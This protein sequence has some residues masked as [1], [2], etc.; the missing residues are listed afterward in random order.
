MSEQHEEAL[1]PKSRIFETVFIASEIVVIL[2]YAF[3][4]TYNL[5]GM[6]GK[7]VSAA[8]Q[9]ETAEKMQGYY[10]MWQDVHVMIYIGFG[11]LMVFLKT[12]SWSAVGFNFLLSAWA[13]QWGILTE[14]FWHQVFHNHFE[15]I[16]L[17][18]TYLVLGDFCAAACM[19][20]FGA[21]LGKADLYQLWLLITI[22]CIFYSLN[23]GIGLFV[24]KAADAGG[25]MFIHTFGAYFGLAATYFFQ[26]TKA[27]KEHDQKCGGGY[28]S[29]YV[30]ML[31]TIFLYLYWPSFN[32]AL[33]P[34]ISKQRAVFTT[35]LSISASCIA[36]CGISRLIHM[37]LD[38][39]IVLNAT[40]AGGVMVGASCDMI[41]NPG[42]AIII[43][44]V[45]GTISALGFAYLSAA[46]RQSINLHD[47]C[48]V[49]NLH[50]MPGF[51]GGITAAICAALAGQNFASLDAAYIVFP[52]V[53]N[54]RTFKQQAGYQLAALFTTMGIA[55]LSGAFA[56][57]VASKVGRPPKNLFEDVEHWHN[58]QY[59][60][61][62]EDGD[63]PAAINEALE[64][65]Q[66]LKELKEAAQHSPSKTKN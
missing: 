45:A 32:A 36:A 56:G 24:F 50:G 6:N 40:I 17:D 7:D 51:L 48:G 41:T 3:C 57:F 15:R 65:E 27:I 19:I 38:M 42:T 43:G 11:F 9:L 31:G 12:F 47:T 53:K 18:V 63:K 30:A 46:L 23:E 60:T 58:V 28:T 52:E 37:K 62:V 39:E 55:L 4:T 22:E 59:D 20:T 29:Q 25:S 61:P 13:F 10:P 44:S 66:A 8:A 26:P 49:N 2:L 21:V 5:T 16:P 33:T 64:T 1:P 34:D 54:G 14:G 35:A